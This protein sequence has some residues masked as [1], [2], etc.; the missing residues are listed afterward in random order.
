MAEDIDLDR[1][2]ELIRQL[3]IERAKIEASINT[4]RDVAAEIRRAAR[5]AN[6]A[7]GQISYEASRLRR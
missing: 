4:G 1:L 5:S 2:D 6:K 3:S 7:A